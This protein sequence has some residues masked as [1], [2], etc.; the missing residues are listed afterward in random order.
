MQQ[1]NNDEL[2]AFL[3]SSPTPYHAVKNLSS[4][5]IDAGFVCV[6]EGDSRIS[7]PNAKV[8]TVR[9]GSA[10]LAYKGVDS[11]LVSERGVRVVGAHTDSPCLKVKPSPDRYVKGYHLAAIQPY[12]GVLLAPWF[13]RDLSLAGH[14]VYQDD[15]GR[16]KDTL[17]DFCRPIGV[18]PSLA[19][20]L[21]RTAN[22]NR[23]VNAHTDM[24]VLLGTVDADATSKPSIA[25]LILEQ[26][27]AQGLN[28]DKVLDYDL[29]F[30]DVQ[31]PA[32]IGANEEFVVSARLDNLLSTFIGCKALIDSDAQAPSVFISNDHEE[33]GSQSLTGAKG[34]LL[35]QW[36]DTSLTGVKN[37]T[38]C[39]SRS[40]MLS[41][42]NAHG[43]HPNFVAKHDENLGPLLN[44]GP[45]IKY[46]MNQA[47]AT[48]SRTSGML[49]WLA[50]EKP[51]IDLQSFA[52]RAD[53]RCGS[54]IGPI[55]ATEV[56]IPTVDIGVP[57]FGMHSIRE[58]AGARDSGMLHSLLIRFFEAPIVKI[59]E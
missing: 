1:Y 28:A 43:V 19:I 2:L 22:E 48:S 26:L 20:H 53:M 11:G 55:T 25:Q 47:Y 7:Q 10:I 38:Q 34:T 45:V 37:K 29:C 39:L 21:D 14:V 30:Y 5:L 57:T 24:N 16:V 33:V 54:T 8:F 6:E 4:M 52:I 40:L 31:A 12:G 15:I 17:I 59:S 23:T 58:T 35:K 27:G 13:D 49:K 41:V 32:I 50:Q 36:L 44:Q 9:D 51:V 18:V 56:G 42:D 3:R 46:D